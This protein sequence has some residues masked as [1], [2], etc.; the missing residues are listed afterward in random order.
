MEQTNAYRKL[1]ERKPTAEEQQ[2]QEM[3]DQL[4]VLEARN[5]KLERELMEREEIMQSMFSFI[6][7]KNVRQKA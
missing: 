3:R 5:K 7:D 2:L 4:A 6:Q 1:A